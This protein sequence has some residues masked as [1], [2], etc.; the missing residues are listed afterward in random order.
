MA[1]S[2]RETICEIT[3]EH[4]EHRWGL[5]FGQTLTAVGRVNGTLPE[6]KEGIVELPMTD[7]AGA[8]IA[9]GAAVAGRRP[10]LV[11]RFGD[12]LTLNMS[13][14]VNFA[15]KQK[16][17]WG[18]RAPIFV[19]LISQEGHGT[20]PTH[21]GKLHALACHF[22]GLKVWAPITPGEYRAC[23]DDFMT[24]DD[25]MICCE[26]RQTYDN[27]EE[28]PDILQPAP[29]V[30]IYAISLARMAA[31]E[32][33][34]ILNAAGD[35]R[36]SVVHVANLREP[37]LPS[38]LTYPLDCAL[39]GL[40]V[41]TSFESCGYGRDLA[42]RLMMFG[43][44]ERPRVEAMGLRDMSCGVSQATEN[45]TPTAEMI[46]DRVRSMVQN[47]RYKNLDYDRQGRLRND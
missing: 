34:R 47:G 8:G 1:I 15:A 44:G 18:T 38:R 22:P 14:I 7:V 21:S 36:C 4:L 46:V 39:Y 23:W 5:V 16:D 45:P 20:G 41:D 13:P 6:C 29:H 25:P 10:I 28:M 32:A 30:V 37:E 19:R 42:Y 12:F 17:I 27:A 2:L 3:R 40:V 43:T 31:V 33:A 24:G 35:V 9:V 11:L 26:H